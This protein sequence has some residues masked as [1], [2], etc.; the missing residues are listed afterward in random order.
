[1]TC[2]H[3]ECDA[4]PFGGSINGAKVCKLHI[5][6]AMTL[7]FAPIHRLEAILGEPERRDI[8]RSIAGLPLTTTKEVYVP[9]IPSASTVTGD[10]QAVPE[11]SAARTYFKSLFVVSW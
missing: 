3:P 8:T 10:S 4:E 1:M 7:A 2:D 11:L 6:W 9:T 5:E